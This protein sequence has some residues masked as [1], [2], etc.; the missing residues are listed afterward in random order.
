MVIDSVDWALTWMLGRAIDIKAVSQ[1][2]S[3]SG[4]NGA[5][6]FSGC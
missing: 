6:N 2:S 3:T 1:N 4:C 5:I